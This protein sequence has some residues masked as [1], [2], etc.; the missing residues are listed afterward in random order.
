MQ[1]IE[2]I[3]DLI[4]HKF[5]RVWYDELFTL[6]GLPSIFRNILYLGYASLSSI[7]DWLV[8]NSASWAQLFLPTNQ[9]IGSKRSINLYSNL[10]SCWN[11]IGYYMEIMWKTFLKVV[12]Y[13]SPIE[14]SRQ[15]NTY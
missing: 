3:I 9:L 15:S 14:T 2:A 8:S 13:L 7:A 5:V 11:L 10:L 12:R 1:E 4:H 6:I